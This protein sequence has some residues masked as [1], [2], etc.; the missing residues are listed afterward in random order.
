M[1]SDGVLPD[2][3]SV[4][5]PQKSTRS[6]QNGVVHLRKEDYDFPAPNISEDFE[7]WMCSSSRGENGTKLT[8]STPL[9]PSAGSNQSNWDR[10]SELNHVQAY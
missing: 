6:I 9:L 7:R 3:L 4:E 5:A 1:D 2:G 8:L 10:E